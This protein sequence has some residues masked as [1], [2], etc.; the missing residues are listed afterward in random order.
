MVS[1]A[2]PSLLHVIRTQSSAIASEESS[3]SQACRP[4]AKKLAWPK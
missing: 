2:P 3:Q 4:K 1:T